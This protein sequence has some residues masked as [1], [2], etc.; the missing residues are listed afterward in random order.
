MS[1][2]T[3]ISPPLALDT[4]PASPGVYRFWGERG[5]LLYIG[6]SINIRQRVRTHFHNTAPRARR[7]CS[8]TRHIDFTETAGELGALLLE[9]QE[10]KQRQPI[11]NRRQRRY[12]Q[13][14][15][16]LLTPVDQGFLVPQRYQ[17]DPMQPLWQQDC[18]GVFRSPRQAQ[19]AL[20]HW[21]KT[22][23]LCPK[24]CGLEQGQGPCFSFQLGRCRGA[25]CGKESADEH[26]QR[27][28]DALT[29]HQIQAWPFQGTLVIHEQG[30]GREDFHLIHQWCHVGT[31]PHPPAQHDLSHGADH[32]FDL[33]SYRM[34]LLFLNRG[35]RYYVME[36]AKP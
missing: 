35:V 6:K 8:Q 14:Q 16:W 17:P 22:Y 15:T 29:E 23:Q 31:L 28:T 7:M 20:E 13:L 21:V 26:N 24:I 10:I 36:P 11:F 9:N 33:D 1:S 34:L 32:C 19:H 4:L 2:S 27:L 5:E 18:Y 12:R 3:L 30:E 25:C